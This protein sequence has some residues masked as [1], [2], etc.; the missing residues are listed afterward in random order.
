MLMFGG[1]IDNRYGGGSNEL[2]ALSLDGTPAWQLIS[3]DTT[4]PSSLLIARVY[5]PGSLMRRYPLHAT[6]KAA[7]AKHLRTMDLPPE[8]MGWRKHTP[9]RG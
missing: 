1:E 6:T 3:N 9:S 7:I 5:S 8:G 2:W 4:A